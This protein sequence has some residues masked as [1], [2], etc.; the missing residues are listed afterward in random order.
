MEA[1]PAESGV[2]GIVAPAEMLPSLF[3]R[4][5]YIIVKLGRHAER[6]DAA[7]DVVTASWRVRQQ[8][9]SLVLLLQRAQTFEGVGHRRDAVVNNPPKIDDEAVILR[10]QF[11]HAGDQLKFHLARTSLPLGSPE[12]P[13][14]RRVANECRPGKQII[15]SNLMDFFKT[16]RLLN[17]SEL[18]GTSLRCT[19][20]VRRAFLERWPI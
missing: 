18:N 6:R 2:E 7:D 4:R 15:I 5:H 17:V 14:S 9:D 13:A 19:R 8:N 1:T 16:R 3:S 12:Q 11:A 10:R 20:F